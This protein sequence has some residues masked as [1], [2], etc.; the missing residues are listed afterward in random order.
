MI[1]T[2]KIIAPLASLKAQ[3]R[4]IVHATADEYYLPD[5]LLEQ[6]LSA[7]EMESNS[8]HVK[9]LKE[10]INNFSFPE[11]YLPQELVHKYKPWIYIRE[12]AI[13]YLKE[14]GFDLKQWEENE[15]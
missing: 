1:R 10:Q 6:T 14:V 15:L 5:E 12:L 9:K 8:V 7:L 11:P 13:A 2:Q 3:E 4:Y